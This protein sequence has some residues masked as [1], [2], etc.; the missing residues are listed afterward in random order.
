MEQYNIQ[1]GNLTQIKDAYYANR[2]NIYANNHYVFRMAYLHGYIDVLDWL[3]SI[4]PTLYENINVEICDNNNSDSDIECIAIEKFL[5]ENSISREENIFCNSDICSICLHTKSNIITK[6]NHQ[7]CE[8][9]TFQCYQYGKN[10]CSLCRTVN[11][12]SDLCKII[13]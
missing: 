13:D 7:F 1:N 8:Y 9:C 5:I 11:L 12:V 6:C 10:H 3:H 2:L 4:N